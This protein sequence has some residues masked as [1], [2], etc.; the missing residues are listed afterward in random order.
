MK[1]PRLLS[2]IN[3]F[4][5]SASIKKHDS[6]LSHSVNDPRHETVIGYHNPSGWLINEQRNEIKLTFLALAFFFFEKYVWTYNSSGEEG[7]E[8]LK[9]EKWMRTI[10]NEAINDGFWWFWILR[11]YP[12]YYLIHIAF[13]IFNI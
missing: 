3:Y 2:S 8:I 7:R 5:I 6:R 12:Q 1:E 9:G 11:M 13:N 10:Q 4:K